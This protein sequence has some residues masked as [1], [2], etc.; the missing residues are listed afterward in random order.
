MW[1]TQKTK[2]IKAGNLEKLIEFLYTK[3]EMDSSYVNVFFATYRTF[4]T[5][6]EVLDSLIK[7][8]KHLS[9]FENFMIIFNAL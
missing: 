8:Y 7:R 3:G 4:T 6:E 5:T 2:V 9:V 1:E